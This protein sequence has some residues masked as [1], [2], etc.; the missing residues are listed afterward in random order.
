V[1]PHTFKVLTFIFKVATNKRPFFFW[2]FI[3]FIS[4]IL[5][6]ITIYQFS[7]A[8]KLLENGAP[9]S[10]L[11]WALVTIFL[12]RIA[13][14]YL[15]LRSITRL[16][17]E[18][19]SISFDIHN[20]FLSDLKTDT[21]EERHEIVQSIRNFADASTVTLN[22]IKQP[23]IDSFVSLFLIPVIL[24]FLDF[25]VFILNFAYIGIYYAID[26]Y[27]TQRYAHLKN[28]LNIH[29]ETYYAKLQDS[30]D[31]DLEQRSWSRHYRRLTNWGFTEWS[32]LQNTAVIFYSLILL[33]LIWMVMGGQKQI[34]D[35][36]MIMGYVTQTQVLLN[37]I[38]SIK[39][40][41]TDMLVGLERL[42]KNSS[43]S[44]ID[45]D[46]LI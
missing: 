46:D 28:I 2:L 35:L 31:F 41:L 11:F 23:G 17:H 12:V 18:I 24:F 26:Y 43:V 33:Y 21:K 7:E 37:S 22:L 30:N 19:S 27:T 5:P 3:R 1:N 39:D 38:S 42:A 25:R 16:E 13:D 34:S 36:V 45:L 10:T 40:S 20:F 6:L 32:L 29:T 8:I 44:T 4:A 14:N 15:R 9:L